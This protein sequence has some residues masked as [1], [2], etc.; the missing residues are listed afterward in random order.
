VDRYLSPVI[1]QANVSALD[2]QAVRS[3]VLQ[4]A[5]EAGFK[6]GWLQGVIAKDPDVV[7][8]ACREAELTEESWYLW[9]S[10]V[11]VGTGAIDVL[12]LS[13]SGRIGIVE[14][15][16][17]Y[18]P[19]N[20]RTVLAQVLDYAV[21]FPELDAGRLPP[22]PIV[23]ATPLIDPDTLHSRIQEGDYLLV[24][25]GERL[26]SR[27]V[28]LSKSLL[29]RHLIRGWDLALV[30]VAVFGHIGRASST[31][32]ILVPHLRGAVIPERRQ[33]VRV[34]VEG[35]R[36]RIE[37]DPAA[38]VALTPA[39]QKWTEARAYAEF[40]REDT[41]AWL[42]DCADALRRIRNEHAGLSIEPGTGS[43]ATLVLKRNGKGLLELSVNGRL[44]FR[45][46]KFQEALGQ[47]H[48]AR[49]REGL[50]TLLPGTLKGTH[51]GVDL[52]PMRD[53]ELLQRILGLV[54]DVLA[55]A[56]A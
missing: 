30:E 15:K 36:T 34:V 43:T 14:T 37:V 12:L 56:E 9:S 24:I 48:S 49:Y 18:N 31:E 41:P 32:C 5:R 2:T 13:E 35:D 50:D 16:L 20:R 22:I 54:Q 17:S 23:N 6:E 53:H 29:G 28:Q 4:T 38:P 46:N 19:E 21:A 1:Y 33:V 25:A 45:P 44:A 8:A 39:R 40:E 3:H 47:E 27:V 11:R 55:R 26:H 52:D 51:P 10:N 7:I 42:R